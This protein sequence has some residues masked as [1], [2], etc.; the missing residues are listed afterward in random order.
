MGIDVPVSARSI[1]PEWLGGVLGAAVA[2]FSVT[3]I[4]GGVMSDVYRVHD[5][6]YRSHGDDLP[7]SLVVK[8]ATESDDRRTAAVTFQAYARELH[9][10]RELAPVAPIRTPVLYAC[11]DDGQ[12]NPERFAIVME[13]LSACAKVFD[14]ISSPPDLPSARRMAMDAARLHAYFWGSAATRLPWL[15]PPDGSYRFSLDALTRSSPA[16]LAEFSGLWREMY[17]EQLFDPDR[18]GD[19]THLVTVLCGP[20]CDV[21]HDRLYERFSSRPRTVLHGDMRADN[22]FRTH[23]APGVPADEAQLIFLDWQVAHAGPPGLEF[24]EA[25]M[26]SLEPEVRRHD[27]A[28][29][30]DY[31]D[32]LVELRPAAA[33]YTYEML[34][35]DY[36]LGCCLW[37]MALVAVGAKTLPAFDQP[38]TA[39][40][41]LLWDKMLVRSLTAVAE[42]D[43]L[44]L[45]ESLRSQPR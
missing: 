28:L 32:R 5:I 45:I 38:G 11:V 4:E 20:S 42:L 7:S 3:A 9:F 41:K 19:A 37:L 13:D 2:S 23:P 18:F 35:E 17:G 25:W 10:F 34:V 22:L 1:T 12:P 15:A 40:M 43:C 21:I 36:S 44:S 27:L 6:R 39:R 14:Q 33:R 29:L 8:M 24:S 26:H 30:R 16:S 31:H